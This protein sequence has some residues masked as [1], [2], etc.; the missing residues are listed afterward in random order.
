MTKKNKV[1]C[2]VFESGRKPFRLLVEKI[3]KEE[4]VEYLDWLEELDLD[5]FSIIV[6]KPK[7]SM[8]Y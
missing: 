5:S 1:A 7:D 8:T 2:F 3:T 4:L 6:L